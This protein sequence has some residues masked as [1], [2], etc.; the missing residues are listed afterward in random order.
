MALR[1]ELSNLHGVPS[2]LPGPRA[3][4]V[5]RRRPR[6]GDDD[7]QLRH[8]RLLAEVR[9]RHRDPRARPTPRRRG[10]GETLTPPNGNTDW[11]AAV[12]MIPW[13]QYLYCGD[14]DMLRRHYPA[15]RQFVLGV[16]AWAKDGASSPRATATG[17]RPKCGR[18][19]RRSN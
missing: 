12:V 11:G 3:V 14:A 8:G 19:R 15:M 17:A 13:Y 5:A 18:S 10:P 6:D 4:R 2:R 1:T 9:P 16:K 7:L